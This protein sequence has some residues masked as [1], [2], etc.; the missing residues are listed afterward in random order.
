MALVKEWVMALVKE[1]VTESA[2]AK[3]SAKALGMG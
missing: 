3:A 2:K 1:W